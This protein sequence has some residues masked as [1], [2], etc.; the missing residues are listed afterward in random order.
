MNEGPIPS[1]TQFG[2]YRIDGIIGEGGMGVVYHAFDTKLNRPAAIKVLSDEI[3]DAAACRRFQR[4]AQ[5]VSSLNHPHILTVYDAGEFDWRWGPE[6]KEPP[7]A[8]RPVIHGPVSSWAR[9]R[10]LAVLRENSD[11]GNGRLGL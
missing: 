9:W 10:R 7:E 2:A 4:E 11:A 5:T 8:L 1:G 6:W 3:A